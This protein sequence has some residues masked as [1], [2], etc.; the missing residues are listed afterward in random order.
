[1]IVDPRFFQPFGFEREELVQYLENAKRDLR[2]ARE[3]PFPEVT[4]TYSFQ[5]LIKI[6]I[7]VIA[8][9]DRAKVRSVPGHHVKILER[10]SVLLKSEDVLVIGNAMRTKRNLDFY[11]GGKMISEKE[12]EEYLTFVE[13]VM[14]RARTILERTAGG[15][16][17]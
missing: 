5:A 12:S 1:M 13:G 3:D 9:K 6:G 16:L 15:T 14:D 8:A 4:F 7:A 11:G 10:L 2:I 17:S